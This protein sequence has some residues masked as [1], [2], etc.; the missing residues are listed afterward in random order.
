MWTK[1]RGSST[2]SKLKNVHALTQKKFR[3]EQR[4]FLV[5]G[6]RL[7]QE[8][9]NS[10]Y[11]ILE[12][13][14]SP[15]VAEHPLGKNLLHEMKRKVPAVYEVS[16]KDLERISETVNSQGVLAIVKQMTVTAD[17]MIRSDESRSVIVA[18]DGVSDPGNVGTMVRTCDWFGVD[19]IVLGRNSVE[20]YNSKVLRSTA[21]GIFHLPIAEGVDLLPFIS[22]AKNAGYKVYVTDPQ[23]ESHF[24]RI[25]YENK[26]VIV[27][28]NEAWGISDQ[29]RELADFRIII[30]RYGSGESLNVGVACG[31][32][33]SSLHRLY[34]E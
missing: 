14:H 13:Y 23:G 1:L 5:E 10:N 30:R 33:L 27:F 15:E 7:V 18:F 8:A 26:S 29:L 6:I 9:L 20:L 11:E 16:A 22:N 2:R 4:K 19:G 12:V 32:I 21:G 24:D 17:S 25:R 28:G 3:D 34:D 31:I